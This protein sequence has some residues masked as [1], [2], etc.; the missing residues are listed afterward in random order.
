MVAIE[1]TL[2]GSE[3]GIRRAVVRTG[4]IDNERRRSKTSGSSNT[5]GL[6]VR[7]KLWLP[8]QE[9]IFLLTAPFIEQALGNFRLYL[10]LLCPK[11]VTKKYF[12]RVSIFDSE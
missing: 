6:A 8:D 10:N 12:I 2:T 4:A 1:A 5:A 11:A 9:D 3:G 7:K